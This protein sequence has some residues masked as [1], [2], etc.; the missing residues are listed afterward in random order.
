MLPTILDNYVVKWEGENGFS[1]E[2]VLCA[3]KDADRAG[4]IAGADHCIDG[5]PES[6][7]V[8]DASDAAW[9][10]AMIMENTVK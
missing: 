6:T 10:A 4:I 2:A 8:Y 9:C 7:F 3:L 1:D 5:A